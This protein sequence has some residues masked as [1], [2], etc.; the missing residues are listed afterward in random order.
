MGTPEDVATERHFTP[1]DKALEE[2]KKHPY[3]KPA[4]AFNRVIY[5]MNHKGEWCPFGN[6][7]CQEGICSECSIY[8]RLAQERASKGAA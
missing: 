1:P 3:S 6:T 5:G 8:Q 4:R 7:T 2:A